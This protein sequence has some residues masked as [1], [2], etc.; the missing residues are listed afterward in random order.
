MEQQST[1]Q[2][3]H[4]SMQVVSLFPDDAVVS[5]VHQIANALQRKRGY[6][7]SISVYDTRTVLEAAHLMVRY[8]QENLKEDNSGEELGNDN[9]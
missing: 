8:A 1:Q 4:Q 5:G 6:V 9:K 3:A 2:S 7:T